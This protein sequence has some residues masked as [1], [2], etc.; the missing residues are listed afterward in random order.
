MQG[1][2]RTVARSTLVAVTAAV[3]AVGIILTITP[4]SSQTTQSL[5]LDL[6]DSAP[7]HFEDVGRKGLS[8]GDIFYFKGAVFDEEGTK[9]GLFL[10]ESAIY[11]R[12]MKKAQLFATISLAGG[13]LAFQGRFNFEASD[14]GIVALTGGTGTY[15][16][17]VGVLHSTIEKSGKVNLD[18][19]LRN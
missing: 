13:D 7:I 18:I 4:A 10:G 15:E 2:T 17:A 16:G 12:N 1:F 5:N 3:A 19:T 8:A 11:G 9:V 14:Q 6:V